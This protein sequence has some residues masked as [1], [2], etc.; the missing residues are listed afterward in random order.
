M[1]EVHSGAEILVKREVREEEKIADK[2]YVGEI[3]AVTLVAQSL[4]GSLRSGTSEL[5]HQHKWMPGYLPSSSHSF[6][7]CRLLLGA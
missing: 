1:Q 4:W 3:A 6:T 7:G 5:P 2:G